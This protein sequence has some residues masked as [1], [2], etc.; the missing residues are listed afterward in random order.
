[1]IS[2][3]NPLYK[4]AAE[5]GWL[6]KDKRTGEAYRYEWDLS[7]FGEVLTPLPDSGILD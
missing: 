4:K 7:P 2:V 5:K 6:I 3:K 1:M